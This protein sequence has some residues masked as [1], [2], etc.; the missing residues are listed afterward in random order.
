MTYGYA[1]V[2]TEKQNLDRQIDALKKY[3]I[4]KLLTEKLTGT[5]QNRPQFKKLLS[6]VKKGDVIVIESLSR[7]GRSSRD[8]LTLIENF[9]KEG[10]TLVSLKEKIDISTPVGK[11][12]VAVLAAQ[13]QF[14]RDC[15][16]ERTNEGLAAA[17]ARG[18][19]GGRPTKTSEDISQA[20]DLYKKNCSITEIQKYTGL[21]RFTIYKYLQI[22]VDNLAAQGL[23]PE[24]IAEQTGYNINSVINYLTK[25]REL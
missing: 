25:K 4:D 21:S 9:E 23:S 18:R 2:S 13:C 1:R 24:E 14:E 10:V 19:V 20:L 12:L 22:K 8:L 6:I 17:R 16:V 3:G 7:L 5:T 11:L 15:V